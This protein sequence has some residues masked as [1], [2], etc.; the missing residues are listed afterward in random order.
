MPSGPAG[1][2]TPLFAVHVH[3]RWHVEFMSR[4]WL[5]RL[6]AFSRAL[7]DNEWKVKTRSIGKERIENRYLRKLE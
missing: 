1:R 6:L 7:D 4:S 3:A 2:G 5:I